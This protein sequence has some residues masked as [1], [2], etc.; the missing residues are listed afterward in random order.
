[1]AGTRAQLILRLFGEDIEKL[2]SIADQMTRVLSKIEGATDLL[3]EK[4]TGQPYLTIEVDRPKIARYG[5]NIS[6]IQN[7]VEIAIAGKSASRF[8]EEN[9]SF[10]IVVRLP[11][12]SRNSIETIAASWCDNR[13]S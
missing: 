11:E 13:R 5:L 6:D 4:V 2:K 12:T 10:D 8:Y 1:V 7:I 3:S 9:R